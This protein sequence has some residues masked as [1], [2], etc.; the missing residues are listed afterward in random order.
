MFLTSTHCSACGECVINGFAQGICP[1]L[2]LTLSVSPVGGVRCCHRGF[3]LD[4]QCLTHSPLGP[5]TRS[6]FRTRP[7]RE[8]LIHTQTVHGGLGLTPWRYCCT[9]S[10]ASALGLRQCQKYSSA[11]ASWTE[12]PSE[13]KMFN[14]K[15]YTTRQKSLTV[16]R[17][18]S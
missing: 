13:S 17:S 9:I 10:Y 12:D 3:V 5:D 7:R 18:I 2:S 6:C 1:I 4:K 15:T 11:C 16:A 8:A 14:K